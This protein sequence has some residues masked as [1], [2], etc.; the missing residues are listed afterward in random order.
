M[1]FYI[2]CKQPLTPP[3]PLGFTRSCCGFSDINVKKCVY[4]CRDKILHNSAKICGQNV[5]FTLKLWQFWRRRNFL[6]F[7][8]K[9]PPEFTNPQHKLRVKGHLWGKCYH[10]LGK[11]YHFLRMETASEEMSTALEGCLFVVKKIWCLW[12]CLR[13]RPT[14]CENLFCRYWQTEFDSLLM[15]NFNHLN[16][17][18]L[19]RLCSMIK[20][21]KG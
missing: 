7:W 8:L 2:L 4:L 19:H 1:F 3:P 20:N 11:Y 14:E 18:F 6:I 12:K 15:N 21:S 9:R 10:F 17:Q 16:S 5:K 13:Q